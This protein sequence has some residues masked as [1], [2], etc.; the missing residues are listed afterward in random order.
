MYIEHY[1]SSLQKEFIKAPASESSRHPAI[2]LR[3]NTERPVRGDDMT[4]L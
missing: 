3:V 4:M 1:G 2:S